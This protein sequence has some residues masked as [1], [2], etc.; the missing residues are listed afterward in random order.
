AGL[1]LRHAGARGVGGAAS[2]RLE[3]AELAG[4]AGAVGSAGAGAGAAGGLAGPDAGVKLAGDE[5]LHAAVRPRHRREGA[6]RE[7]PAGRLEHRPVGLAA[8]RLRPAAGLEVDPRDQAVA[9]G[10]EKE[11]VRRRAGE[12]AA[13]G[14]DAEQAVEFARRRLARTPEPALAGLQGAHG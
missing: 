12:P 14:G 10:V 4:A 11:G 7:D 2:T 8:G 13:L 9:V 1:G 3:V 5:R 6:G